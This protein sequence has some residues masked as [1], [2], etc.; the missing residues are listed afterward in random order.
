MKTMLI[1]LAAAAL[2]VTLITATALA[3]VPS[4]AQS[5]KETFIGVIA[6]FP[7]DRAPVPYVLY[8]PA[9]ESNYFVDDNEKVAPYKGEKVEITGTLDQADFTIHVESVKE[10]K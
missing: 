5:Q 9:R 1:S 7:T 3:K 10:V 8:D 2:S 6:R 4:R